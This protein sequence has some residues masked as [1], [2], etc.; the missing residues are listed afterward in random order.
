MNSAYAAREHF[1]RWAA[2]L[3][4]HQHEVYQFSTI[5]ALLEGVYDGDV[6]IAMRC[7]RFAQSARALG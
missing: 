2:T 1:R 6:T 7:S 3:L 4:A 5:S